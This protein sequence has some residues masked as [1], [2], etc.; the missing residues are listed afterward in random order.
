MKRPKARNGDVARDRKPSV[1]R[2]TR[3]LWREDQNEQHLL[4]WTP[5]GRY[6][7]GWMRMPEFAMS[8]GEPDA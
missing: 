6:R 5:V 1:R 4:A 7:L 2:P 8:S 3:R